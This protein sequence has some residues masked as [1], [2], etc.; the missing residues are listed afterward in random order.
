MAI[1]DTGE[2][3]TSRRGYF[4][5]GVERT[6]KDH[7]TVARGPMYVQWEAPVEVTRPYPVVLVHGG[8]GQGL[9]Y[10]GTPDGR[11]GWHTFLVQEGYAV[12]TVDRPG[13]GRAPYHPDVL[14]PM[15]PQFPYEAAVGL[16]APPAEG[17]MAH[18]TSHLGTQWPGALGEPDEVMDQMVAGSGPMIADFPAAHALEGRRGAELL[19]RIGPAIVIAHSAGGPTGWLMADA[20]PD[21]VKALVAIE[22]IGPPFSENPALGVELEW[23]VT[24]API[25]YDPPASDPSE[26]KTE[27]R[28]PFEPGG[29]PVTLQAE[30]ARKLPNL[31]KFPI[32]VVTSEASVFIQFDRHT[33]AFLEQAGCDVELVRLADRGVR[34]TG[35]AMMLERNNRDSLHVILDWVEQAV[36]KPEGAAGG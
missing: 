19:D 7:G 11:P 8:G 35:H 32:A 13:H 20:R 16:F 6:Q 25:T 22:T 1:H 28:E 5:V 21:L 29:I 18:P 15:T 36:A 9:D 4:W 3:I 33:V 26:L 23:G 14:G 17:P 10:L 27:T 12:Y 31:A 30:P 24:A 2:P 34:G